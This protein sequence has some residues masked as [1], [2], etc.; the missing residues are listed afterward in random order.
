[1]AVIRGILYWLAWGA[2]GPLLL[3]V[4]YVTL[5]RS[6]QIYQMKSWAFAEPVFLAQAAAAVVSAAAGILFIFRPIR[7][8]WAPIVVAATAALN[9]TSDFALF[10]PEAYQLLWLA[11]VPLVA[12]YAYHCHVPGYTVSRFTGGRFATTTDQHDPAAAQTR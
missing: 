12:L 1:M 3:L 5:D 8:W 10:G 9:M 7:W 4:A 2:L 11:I 6:W